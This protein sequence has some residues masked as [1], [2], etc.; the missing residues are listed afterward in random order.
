[1]AVI[2]PAGLQPNIAE[3]VADLLLEAVNVGQPS[4]NLVEDQRATDRYQLLVSRV[5][6]LIADASAVI[7]RDGNDTS[8]VDTIVSPSGS[9]SPYH[10]CHH[11]PPHCF[12]LE[13][14][15][16]PSCP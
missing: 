3:L 14:R 12:D 6:A 8:E 11:S 13:Y 1:M 10:R 15:P 5:Q 9:P 2:E 4:A 7:C 16:L